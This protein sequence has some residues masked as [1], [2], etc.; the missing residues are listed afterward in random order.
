M[1]KYRFKWMEMLSFGFLQ[2]EKMKQAQQKQNSV[3]MN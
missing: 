1:K 2:P 3:F